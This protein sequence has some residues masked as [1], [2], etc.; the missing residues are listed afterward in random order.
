MFWWLLG[1][2]EMILTR[3]ECTELIKEHRC[4]DCQQGPFIYWLLS[5]RDLAG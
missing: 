5:Y 2:A 1:V 3:A 4:S